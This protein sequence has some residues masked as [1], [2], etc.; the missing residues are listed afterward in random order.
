MRNSVG[1]N[2]LINVLYKAL[3]MIILLLQS[4]YVSRILL[5]EGVGQVAYAQNISAYFKAFAE[6]GV[7]IYGVREIARVREKSE[8]TNRIFAEL[9][10]INI[11]TTTCA[12]IAYGILVWMNDGF[13]EQMVLFF[14]CGL[15]ILFNYLNIEWFY[16]GKEEYVYIVLRSMIVK[17]F[18]L[19]AT[20]LFVRT[21]KD[22]VIYALIASA[23]TGGNCFLN[24]IRARNHVRFIWKRLHPARHI[25]SLMILSTGSFLT[26]FY[27][28]V[29]LTMLGIVST[30]EITGY[31]SYASMAVGMIAGFCT[32]AIHVFSPRLSYYYKEEREKFHKL[33]QFE[34]QIL[35]FFVVPAWTGI[36]ILTPQI[37]VTLF[38][39][40]FLPASGIMRLLSPLILI[41]SISE[42]LGYQMILI[43]NRESI[44]VK[45]Y[46][47]MVVVTIILDC[48]LIPVYAG[49]AA[50]L[51]YVAGELIVNIYLIR[52]VHYLV[53]YTVPV[54]AVWQ[55]MISAGIM[56]IA[57]QY[58]IGIVKSPLVQC[59]IGVTIGIVVY[60]IM[61]LLLKNEFLQFL[62]DRIR[63]NMI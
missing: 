39:T 58:G 6:F 32:S 18:S 63:K 46:F 4:T 14:V 61:N 62:A 43:T 27:G 44:I 55:A 19:L 24:V 9:C 7:M 41:W 29:S 37:V 40:A 8:D 30:K 11:V 20:F 50:A 56:G 53:P 38:G 34:M 2:S 52:K 57:I 59:M 5:A 35:I 60:G 42:A 47:I 17:I 45:S 36:F 49:E 31:Y 15:H 54:S 23:A 21:E 22:Y 12:L 26:T 25:K 13:R 3:D 28:T 51:I 33:L 48:F 16:Q 1:K 10:Q